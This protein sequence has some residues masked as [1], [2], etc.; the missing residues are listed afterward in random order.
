MMPNFAVGAKPC[1]PNPVAPIPGAQPECGGGQCP[2]NGGGGGLADVVTQDSDTLLF[3][4]N[5]TPDDP[6]TA[7][8]N[9]EPE[10]LYTRTE[11]V[12]YTA[13]IQL[14]ANE[15]AWTYVAPEQT[16]FDRNFSDSI[17][18]AAIG[19]TTRILVRKNGTRVG[20]INILDGLV[21]FGTIGFIL[22]RGDIMTFVPEDTVTPPFI[23]FT[24]VAAVPVRYTQQ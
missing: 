4:G 10:N 17:G 23:S 16:V 6:L 24:I 2:P 18:R 15:D 11:F 12:L 9:L 3:T 21:T 7:S 20:E 5:G 14:D 13:Q 22:E 1:A 19:V 8:L